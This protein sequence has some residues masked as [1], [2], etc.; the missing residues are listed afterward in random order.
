[1]RTL[2]GTDGVRG[3]AGVDLTAELARDLGAAAAAWAGEGSAVLIGRDTRESGPELEEALAEGIVW[4]GGRAV[5]AG[6][7]PT[8]GVAVLVRLG[9]AELGCV[10]SA[11]HNPYQDNGI[12]F[13]GGDGRKLGDDPEAAIE[14]LVGSAPAVSGGSVAD[15]TGAVPEYAD[16][17]VETYGDGVTAPAGLVA[18]C[19]NGA[20]HAAAPLVLGRLGLDAAFIGDEPDGRNINAGVGSTHLEAVSAAVQAAGA[21]CGIAFDGDADR[22]LA[23]DAVGRPVNGDAIIAAIALARRVDRVVVT[24]MTNL[25]FHRLMR[26]HG[27]AVEVTDVGD[28]YVLERMLATGATLGGEQSGHVVDLANHTTGDGLA[29]ALMLLAALPQL[30][31]SMAELADLIVPFPQQLVAVRAD[32]K[33][34]AGSGRIWQEVAAAEAKLG[35]DGR[36]VLRASGTEPVVRVMVEAADVASCAAICDHLVGIVQLEIGEG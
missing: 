6:V 3:V 11:S 10:I 19:A 12:K 2:F 35:E 15:L 17:L 13:L 36:V 26:E 32:R 31:M 18:D 30:G 7:I 33:A 1:M 4:G 25:G 29:T 22:C 27:I 28:R 5:H 14:R 16:W 34:L 24:S 23:V 8:P 20:A 21:A 9:E